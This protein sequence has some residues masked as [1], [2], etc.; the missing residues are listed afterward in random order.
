MSAKSLL[1]AIA[2]FFLMANIRSCYTSLP[3]SGNSNA[4]FGSYGIISTKLERQDVSKPS[5]L[6][7]GNSVYYGTEVI[8]KIN[9]LMLNDS[10]LFETGNFGFTGASVFDYIFN[11][12]H[13][14]QYNPDLVV[15]Q[16]NPTSFG[17]A[18]PY[19]RN[20][21]NN[22][23]FKIGRISL[24]KEKFIRRTFSKDDLTKALCHS[25]MPVFASIKIEKSKFRNQIKTLTKS[26]TNL[27]LWTF[28]PNRI[29]A[30]GEWAATN[31]PNQ[32]KS[33]ETDELF[34]ASSGER[35]KRE[36]KS[37]REAFLFFVN[38]LKRDNQKALFI[39]QP[40]GFDRLPLME[41]MASLIEEES[42]ISF[43]DYHH[44]FDKKI[45]IDK[46]HPNSD[47]ADLAAKRH[48]KLIKTILAK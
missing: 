48:Y 40:S 10:P 4:G 22:S 32:I 1:F 15:V 35:N 46:I 5:V 23:L 30:V 27:R 16:F 42:L 24:L 41:E 11:Y 13:L 45:Y 3:I 6:F 33:D 25:F 39:I 18:G 43:V 17:Y 12:E 34:I 7:M 8:P 37:A 19:Y 26:I 29:N 9:E 44:F 14:K 2:I 20:D 28:F 38:Q 21:G 47:G 36:Y 31:K